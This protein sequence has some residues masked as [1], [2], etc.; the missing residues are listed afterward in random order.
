MIGYVYLTTNTVNNKKYVGKHVSSEFDP[1]YKGS[2]KLILRALNKYGTQNFNTVVIEKCDTME[3][4]NECE[5]KWI[6]YYNAV[7]SKNFYN[8]IESYSGFNEIVKVK[9]SESCKGDLNPFYKGKF[10]EE[11]LEHLSKVRRNQVWITDGN[12][13]YR[14]NKEEAE[15]Y[16][17]D[18]WKRGRLK[19]IPFNGLHNTQQDKVWMNNNIKSIFVKKEE[20]LNFISKGYV[21]GRTLSQVWVNNS[22][23]EKYILSSK[24]QDYLNDNWVRGRLKRRK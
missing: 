2:G 17:K 9:K 19:G 18:G 14:M 5:I 22:V 11:T 8:L 24:L 12:K 20:I 7:K 1:F 10:S 6:K 4:L 23:Q 15:S 16:L 21:L 13:E 3:Q